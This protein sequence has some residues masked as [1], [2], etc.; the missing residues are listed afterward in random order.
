MVTQTSGAVAE[1]VLRSVSKRYRE[2]SWRLR[3]FR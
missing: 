3:T 1:V 2:R